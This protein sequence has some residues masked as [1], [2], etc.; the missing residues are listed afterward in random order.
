MGLHQFGFPR[1]RFLFNGVNGWL[2]TGSYSSSRNCMWIHAVV[3]RISHEVPP[4]CF[5]LP[6]MN[7]NQLVGL[8]KIERA[9]IDSAIRALQGSPSSTIGR[10]GK[11]SSAA[12]AKIA[13]AQRERWKKW[14][15]ANK[16][17]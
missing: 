13:K 4:R 10:R 14:K 16:R 17:K 9:R 1:P 2:T 8:L 6:V 3:S 12:R 5:I 15:A 7:V 11:L